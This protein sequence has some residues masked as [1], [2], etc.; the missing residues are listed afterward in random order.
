MSNDY[1]DGNHVSNSWEVVNPSKGERGEMNAMIHTSKSL[2]VFSKLLVVIP[3]WRNTKC[4]QC[5]PMYM[6]AVSFLGQVLSLVEFYTG[7]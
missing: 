3:T 2:V 1:H 6:R 4:E 5:M 7:C